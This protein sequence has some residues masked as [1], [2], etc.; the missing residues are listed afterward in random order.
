M[1]IVI[2]NGGQTCN[3]FWSYLAPLEYALKNKTK[4]CVLFPDKELRSYPNLLDNDYLYFPFSGLINNGVIS[5]VKLQKYLRSILSNRF[6]NTLPS[7]FKFFPKTFWSAWDDR[8]TAI[9]PDT[10]RAMKQIFS[11]H[12]NIIEKVDSAFDSDNRGQDI[13]IGVHIR[14]GDYKSWLNGRYYFSFEIYRDVCERI[15]S[16]FPGRKCRFFISSAEA[17]DPEIFPES[18]YFSLENG[19]SAEDLYALSKCDYIIG[20]PSTFSRWAAF[21]GDKPIR[22]IVSESDMTKSFRKLSTLNLYSTG[23]SVESQKGNTTEF[24]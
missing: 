20:P 12:K 22:F 4:V 2:D 15:K 17:V 14:R 21:Y 19:S 18:E 7:L 3:K 13:T 24:Q 9:S 10:K 5:P 16:E 11:P 1:K 8:G 23:E 6:Y